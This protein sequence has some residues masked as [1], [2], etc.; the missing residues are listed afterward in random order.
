MAKEQKPKA[1]LVTT[2]YRGVFFGFLES[3]PDQGVVTLIQAQN[4]VYWNS[5]VHGFMGLAVQGPTKE[6]RIGPP[7]TRL[8]LTK[9]TAIIEVSPEAVEAWKG[10]PWK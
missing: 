4:C 10:Q 2:E 6:C 5:A 8:T 3:G 9:V 7:V 1:I